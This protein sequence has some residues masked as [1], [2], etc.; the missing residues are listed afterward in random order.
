MTINLGARKSLDWIFPYLIHFLQ[1]VHFLYTI[2][3]V[4]VRS[5]NLMIASISFDFLCQS[6]HTFSNL[7]FIPHFHYFSK[8]NVGLVSIH[9][10]ILEADIFQTVLQFDIIL[11]YFI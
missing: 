9:H 2:G 1:V 4:K 11:I 3:F 7:T 10:N 6:L 8:V 5:Y